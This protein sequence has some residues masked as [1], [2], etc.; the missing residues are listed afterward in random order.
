M[1]SSSCLQRSD[2]CLPLWPQRL[3]VS[4][5]YVPRCAFC[6]SVPRQGLCT[7]K[8]SQLDMFFLR[9]FQSR[10]RRMGLVWNGY[11]PSSWCY[12]AIFM[13]QW[14]KMGTGLHLAGSVLCG[15]VEVLDPWCPHSR[16]REHL[17]S[18]TR[19]A[20]VLDLETALKSMKW[21]PVFGLEMKY[22]V[23]AP[24]SQNKYRL[25]LSHW[26]PERLSSGCSEGTWRSSTILVLFCLHT[27]SLVWRDKGQICIAITRLRIWEIL[28][29]P[30][31]PL[32]IRS[33]H[34]QRAATA[35]TFEQL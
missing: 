20:V 30:Q 18:E 10:L 5:S 21:P 19:S 22:I 15:L 33:V 29:R 23:Y 25:P 31:S 24:E 34:V 6:P 3:P 8:F 28:L 26:R 35:L 13:Q 16:W 4:S 32:F 14:L 12:Y 9:T 27:G 17:L 7:W 2:L 1:L 11:S